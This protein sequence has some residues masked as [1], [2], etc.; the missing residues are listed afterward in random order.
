M[1]VRLVA[2][3]QLLVI[4]YPT[5]NVLTTAMTLQVND[6]AKDLFLVLCT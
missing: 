5:Q 2:N 4:K 1:M 3:C 6:F